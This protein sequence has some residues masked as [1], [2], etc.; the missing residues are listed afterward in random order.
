MLRNTVQML[1][2]GSAGLQAHVDKSLQAQA[3]RE[4]G[5]IDGKLCNHPRFDEALD[6]FGCRIRAQICYV[7]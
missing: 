3:H 2:H 6:A 5:D 7:T 1:C 4:R